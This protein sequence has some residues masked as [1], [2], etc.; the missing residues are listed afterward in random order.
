MMLPALLA[1]AGAVMAFGVS[2]WDPVADIYYYAAALT[3]AAISAVTAFSLIKY[4]DL[5]STRPV[6][7]F[8]TREGGNDRAK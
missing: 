1:L 6:P 5:L 2:V 3:M 8:F 4:Y 7:S